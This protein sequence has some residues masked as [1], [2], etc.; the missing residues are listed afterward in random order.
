MCF[1]LSVWEIFVTLANGGS[2]ILARNA[3]ELPDLP[4]RDQVHLINTVPSAINALQRAGQIPDSVKIINLAGEPLKQA[5][6]ENLYQQATIKHVYDLYG[7][8]EDTTYSTWTRREAGGQANI[9]RPLHNTQS[10]LLDAQLQPVAPGITAELYL[11]GAGITRGYLLRPGMSAERYVPNPYAA[12]GERMYR[13]GDLA[14]HRADGTLEYV[15]RI[16]HQVKVRGFRIEL[17]EIESRLLAQDSVQEVAVLAMEGSSGQQLVAY[18]VPDHF[19]ANSDAQASSRETIKTALREHLPEYMVPAHLIFLDELPLTPNGKLDRRALPA[20]EPSV[21]TD[22]FIAPQSALEQQ[23]AAIWQDVLKLEHVGLTDNFFELGG[24]SIVSIQ[25]VSRA[26]QA[27]IHFTPKEL[28]QHQTVQGLASITQLT[29][30][31]TGIDQRPVSGEVALLPI[32]QWFFQQAIPE[33]HHWNQSVVLKPHE[34][35]NAPALEHALQGLVAHHDALRL[36]FKLQGT[37]WAGHVV[38]HT[39]RAMLW[40]QDVAD[41]AA[42]VPLYDQAQRSLDLQ[43]GPLLRAVLSNLP[44]GEQRLLIVIHHLVVDGVS[45]RILFEDLQALYRQQISGQTPQLPHKTSSVKAWGERLRGYAQNGALLDEV[46]YWQQQLNGVATDLPCEH[47]DASL[48][49]RHSRNLQVG[50]SQA[51]TRQLLQ[52]APA[53]YRTQ[54]NDL[55]L[56]ALARVVGRWTRRDDTLIQL[57]GH[58][59]EELFDDIDLTRTVGWFTSIFPVKLSAAGTLEQSIK[60]IKEQLRAIPKKGL[61]YGVLREMGDKTVQQTLSGLP[62]P[63]ITFNYL[64]QFDASFDAAQGA[65]FA[66]CGESAGAEQHPDAPLANWLS[67][68]S[69]VYGGELSVSWLYSSQMFD[70]QTIERL[71]D[72]YILELTALIE[73]C[74]QPDNQGTTPSDFPLA[75]LNQRQLDAL[76]VKAAE[77]EDIYPLSPMQQGMLFHSLYERNSGNYINQMRLD[78]EGL[79]PERFQQAWQAVLDA[80]DIL[81]TQFLWQGDLPGPVQLVRKH[82]QLPFTLHDWR[83]QPHLEESLD[84]LAVTEQEGFE[85]NESALLRLQL[86]RTG[87]SRHHLIYTHHHILMDGW[88]NSQLLGEVLQRY[89]GQ[90]DAK[91]AGLYRDYIA[92]LQLQDQALSESFWRGQLVDLTEPTRLAHAI[93]APGKSGKGYGHCPRHLEVA[94]TQRLSAFA[95]QQKVTVNTLLQSAWLLLLQ[96]YTGQN[97]VC[98][99]ATVAGRPAELK[100]IE[101]QIGLFINT[102]PVIASPYAEQTV[103]QWLQTVQAQNLASR[104]HEHTPLFEVQRWSQLSGEGLFDSL[105]VFENYPVSEAL[106]QGGSSQLRFDGIRLQEQTNYPLTLMV[107]MSDTLSLHYHYANSNFSEQAIDQLNRHLTGLLLS[108][109]D[110]PDCALGELSMLDAA[111][112]QVMVQWNS[113]ATDYLLQHSVN[114]L[115][116]TQAERTPGAV[117]LIVGHQ[118]LTYRQLNEQANQ[119]AHKLNASGIGPD[120]LVGIALERGIPMIVSLLATLKAG[121]AYVPLDPDYPA[122]RL[123]YMMQDS[124]LKVLIT[125]SDVLDSLSVP[126]GVQP[127]VYEPASGWLDRYPRSNPATQTSP[128]NLAYVIYT[129]GSTGKPKGVAIAHRNVLALIHWSQQ[130]YSREDIQG[131]LAST[132]VCFDLSVWE[133]FVTLANGGSLI[134]ARNALELPDL[135]ARDQVRLINTVPSAINALQ[136]AGQIPNSVRIINLAG[137]PLKQSL[138]DSLYQQVTIEHVYDLYG[139]SEDTTYSTWSR[140]EAGGQANIGRPLNNTHGYM[141]DADLNPVPVGVAAELHLAGAGITRGYLGK[142]ALTAEKYI[143]NP[144]SSTGER[145]YRTG[146]L[147]RY[148]ADGAIEYVG[149]IDHQVKIRG[150]RIELGEIEAR[151]LVQASVREAAVLAVEGASGLQLVAYIVP[152]RPDGTLDSLETQ[153]QL[154]ESIKIQLKSHLPEHM[155]PA[156]LIFLTELPLTPNGK[157]DRKA[158]PAPDSALSQATFVAPQNALEQQIATIW[159][160]VLKRKQVGINDNFFELGGDSIISIQVVSRA[161][162][163]GIHFTPKELFKH[164]TVQGLASVAQLDQPNMGIDQA[165]V[166]GE[167]PLL[168]IHHQLLGVPNDAT[169]MV[170]EP[171]TP[172]VAEILEE[173]LQA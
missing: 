125:Q 35:L 51:Q 2:L 23:I 88:S 42:L 55:L 18:L 79:D 94:Q 148:R 29:S 74:C 81:R 173:A 128:D 156:Q 6:V 134:L 68:N 4:A 53:A 86:V 131:V 139:P 103:G 44:N 169:L 47:P 110:H 92:W 20:P 126:I 130:V 45:W 155:V 49:N 98:F 95:R 129:S 149:R 135:P 147:T 158:L 113:P 160:D 82:L 142:A 143:P 97:C 64:G 96:R 108:M 105:L 28:F 70:E 154:R 151:L 67:I 10:Y 31:R 136:R 84:T 116:E 167:M 34:A 93:P 46:E 22:Q 124:G 30:D 133:I 52:Q 17:G 43:E 119:L 115:I 157:L 90:H 27:G 9:G 50:L 11:A 145:L 123:A 102:L 144:F 7:P 63:R 111:E 91:P 100:G 58:G 56:T 12:H 1:D 39:P 152:T 166:S 163:A 170:L 168:P 40:Q 71:A 26:R 146:D 132:S 3:L 106:E 21:P 165:L 41:V 61:G 54:I 114:Q 73:H 66:P 77:I 164:Q 83:A 8:S 25:V 87:E 109:L 59:R 85:L 104:E 76:T 107:G 69:Q 78:V 120:C 112:Q 159:Q 138:V 32:H 60:H 14:R 37:G 172:L 65:L 57:E 38:P 15:G 153:A 118:S 127:L 161:R 13:T 75:G 72:D 122:E 121:G 33:R 36:N 80:R 171:H 19:L 162:Q 89:N 62:Q 48:H 16:D 137:E 24:D 141:L 99:G 150:F 5:L 117:A 101:Q 140:R